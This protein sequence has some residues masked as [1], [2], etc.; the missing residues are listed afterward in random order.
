M[1]AE[2][3]YD[4]QIV[5]LNDYKNFEYMMLNKEYK[6]DEENSFMSDFMDINNEWKYLSEEC[7]LINDQ[8]KQEKEENKY[9]NL[10][11]VAIRVIQEIDY[12]ERGL[13]LNIK[14]DL[15]EKSEFWIFTRCF[16]NKDINESCLFDVKSENIDI[17][18]YFNK[19][20]SLTFLY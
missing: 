2:N 14:F 17:N 10:N 4:T 13:E 1:S 6:V 3:F 20:T 5:S 19:Y 16:V 15:M 8:E 18:D 12:D 11:N 9:Y 7:P